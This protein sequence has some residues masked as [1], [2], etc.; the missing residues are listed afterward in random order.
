MIAVS[1]HA[2]DLDRVAGV[3]DRPV[4]LALHAPDEET[5]HS[6]PVRVLGD[7]RHIPTGQVLLDMLGHYVNHPLIAHPFD[8]VGDPPAQVQLGLQPQL[9]GA[10]HPRGVFLQGI[11]QPR[12]L[13]DDGRLPGSQPMINRCEQILVALQALESGLGNGDLFIRQPSRSQRGGAIGCM[14]FPFQFGVTKL[15]LLRVGVVLA[16]AFPV[17][18]DAADPPARGIRAR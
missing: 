7:G 14:E 15:R 16:D 9:L 3:V 2:F 17:A 18:F 13:L 4:P 12:R 11:I 8:K 10:V 1:R 6:P 5:G